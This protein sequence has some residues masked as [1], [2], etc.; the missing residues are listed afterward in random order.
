MANGRLGYTTIPPYSSCVV[1]CNDSGSSASISVNSQVISSSGNTELTVGIGTTTSVVT[2]GITTVA[3]GA[4]FNTIIGPTFA[5][6]S[7]Y[8][9]YCGTFVASQCDTFHYNYIASG[10]TG[11]GTT[12][13]FDELTAS[14]GICCR[15]L[16]TGEIVNPALRLGECAYTGISSSNLTGFYPFSCSTVCRV[17]TYTEYELADTNAA[18]MLISNPCCSAC[19]NVLYCDICRCSIGSDVAAVA[20]DWYAIKCGYG[21]VCGTTCTRFEDGLISICYGNPDYLKFYTWTGC[22]N[23]T[24]CTTNTVNMV[25]NIPKSIADWSGTSCLCIGCDFAPICNCNCGPFLRGVNLAASGQIGTVVLNLPVNTSQLQR[26][27]FFPM[28]YN[29]T[30]CIFTQWTHWFCNCTV[31]LCGSGVINLC[32]NPRSACEYA[33][34]WLSYNPTADCVYFMADDCLHAGI[35][36]INKENLFCFLCK[37]LAAGCY[38]TCC[39]YICDMSCYFTKV[40]NIPSAFANSNLCCIKNLYK[41]SEN[42]WGIAIKNCTGTCFETFVSSDLIN[43]TN[44]TCSYSQALTDDNSK[45]ISNSSACDCLFTTCN[46]F[47]GN[48]SC[49]GLTDYKVSANNYERTG[50][51]I[52][53][54]ESVVV[55]NNSCYTMNA[56]V[57]GYEG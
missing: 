31:G 38:P 16:I 3:T 19:C 56:Q 25:C 15:S 30:C 46:C 34:K 57:W 50:V 21:M 13:T 9:T 43:W 45:F 36:S 23:T 54:G 4:T 17:F 32:F 6:P 20:Y 18:G 2:S 24:Q 48:V 8:D 12:T 39:G 55:N 42:L 51:V 1:Y 53:D 35:Y 11:I 33:I 52:S 26:Y 37:N 27:T 7:N 14:S 29:L 28:S 49:S 41:T 10:P 47:F 22:C 5:S 44:S 40:S